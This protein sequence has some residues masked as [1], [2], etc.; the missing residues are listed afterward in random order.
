MRFLADENFPLEAVEALR[1]GLFDVSWIR[2]ICPGTSDANV[3]SLAAGENRLLLTLD[4]DFGELAFRSGL[5]AASGVML[6]RLSGLKPASM[7]RFIL[8]A[9]K[10]VENPEG[11]FV[12]VEPSR[13][14]LRPLPKIE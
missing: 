14:R 9:I 13:I 2:E 11:F 3:L 12:I 1:A 6:F 7:V 5:P 10:S 8:A 4:K